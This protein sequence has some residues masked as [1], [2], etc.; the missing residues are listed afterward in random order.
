M[1]GRTAELRTAALCIPFGMNDAGLG[2]G[3]R[4]DVPIR[5]RLP[6]HAVRRSSPCPRQGWTR[7]QHPRPILKYSAAT[8][9]SQIAAIPTA[10]GRY[11][12]TA[13]SAKPPDAEQ[14][15]PPRWSDTLAHPSPAPGWGGAPMQVGCRIR[16]GRPNPGIL[17]EPR[18][19]CRAGPARHECRGSELRTMHGLRTKGTSSVPPRSRSPRRRP[20]RLRPSRPS[21]SSSGER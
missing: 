5:A 21:C 8:A 3:L 10:N 7:L 20:G 4:L 15:C 12:L 18:H 6:E 13:I 2:R 1:V 16:H 14:D 17:P 19:S 9:G 11:L